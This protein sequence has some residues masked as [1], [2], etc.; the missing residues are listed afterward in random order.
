MHTD[1]SSA[2]RLTER[3]IGCAFQVL[4]TLGAGFL[5]KVYENALAHELRK[6]GLAIVQQQGITVMYDG[7]VVGQYNVDLLVDKTVIVELK[8]IKSLD[9]AHTA[10]C[11]NY[12]K[13]TGLHLCL[14]LNFGKPRLE[15]QRIAHSLDA[16]R[17]HLC[18]SAC[19]C[20]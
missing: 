13:A 14:L 20:G 9:S 16:A 6:F 15:I 5:E 1:E 3:I 10:Q 12:L 4:N 8:A 2:N 17:C 18:A 7:V 11:I 19:I